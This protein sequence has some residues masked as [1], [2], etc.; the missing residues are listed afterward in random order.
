MLGEEEVGAEFG[1]S[2][3]RADQLISKLQHNQGAA[4]TRWE[5]TRCLKATM[6][7]YKVHPHPMQLALTNTTLH[8]AWRP[9]LLRTH[10]TTWDMLEW[11]EPR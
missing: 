11:G 8:R 9:L 2:N 6:V 4:P 1:A 5:A 7:G 3:S 10:L